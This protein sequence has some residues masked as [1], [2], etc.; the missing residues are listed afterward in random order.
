MRRSLRAPWYGGSAVML[1]SAQSALAHVDEAWHVLLQYSS[2][3][4]TH[5]VAKATAGGVYAGGLAPT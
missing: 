5:F 2:P 4:L 3:T 1:Q